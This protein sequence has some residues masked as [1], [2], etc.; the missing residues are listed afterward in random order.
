V[1]PLPVIAI[2]APNPAKKTETAKIME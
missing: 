1:E 2:A